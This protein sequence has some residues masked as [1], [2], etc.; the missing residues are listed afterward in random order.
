MRIASGL[1]DGTP[2]FGAIEGE[3]FIPFA[4]AHASW[5][6]VLVAACAGQLQRSTQRTPVSALRWLA[7][8]PATGRI[9]CVGLNYALHAREGGH[10]LPDY[11]AIFL[12]G[13][14]SAVGHGEP[15][16]KPALS[17]RFDYEAELAVVIG[18]RGRHVRAADALDLVAG[19]TCFNDGS[20]R[21]FQRKSTQ[22]TMGKNFDASG[23]L[24][25]FVV[26]PDELP[27]G[28][29]GLRIQARLNGQTVQDSTTADMVFG[30]PQL[31]ETLSAVMTLLPGDVIATGTPSGVG[32][33]RTPPLFMQPGD[34][35]EIEIEGIGVLSNPVRAEDAGA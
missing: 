34:R 4:P 24:G 5:Q 1:L 6:A 10:A 16:V 30:V 29:H 28:A 11:P 23:A 35:C 32:F 8:M 25:P 13:A 17:E 14:L 3:H 21:D 18:R 26:T 33:A 31:I 27:A 19:Y 15:L 12:R 22:W 9:I 2:R 20:A 7:P